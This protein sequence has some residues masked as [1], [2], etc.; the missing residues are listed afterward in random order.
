M[1]WTKNPFARAWKAK[2]EARQEARRPLYALV[3]RQGMGTMADRRFYSLD[4]V[5]EALQSFHSI[6]VEGTEKMT[7]IDLVEIGDWAITRD[8]KEISL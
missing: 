8:G 1:D 2:L 5:K 7:L 6:D 3:D 4:E